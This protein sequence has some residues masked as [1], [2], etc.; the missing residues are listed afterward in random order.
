VLLP[1]WPAA[2]AAAVL[3]AP[4][5]AHA[6][7][8]SAPPSEP[9]MSR[10]RPPRS[11]ASAAAPAPATLHAWTARAPAAP[12]LLIFGS[13]GAVWRRI[14]EFPRAAQDRQCLVALHP[15]NCA[16]CTPTLCDP[17]PP[18][19]PPQLPGT[20]RTH[21]SPPPQLPGTNRTHI[22]PSSAPTPRYKSG[23]HLSLVRPNSPVQIGHTSLPRLVQ[24]GSTCPHPYPARCPAR[25]APRHRA[26]PRAGSP[27]A[28]ALVRARPCSSAGL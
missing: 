8:A 6:A 10:R 16:R 28:P 5:R 23:A 22:S 9:F 18:T 21:I 27:H 1:R 25:Q 7:A 24:I 4:S 12:S 2:L 20:N 19:A 14:S 17:P 26:P 11:R 15:C 3:P 13:I